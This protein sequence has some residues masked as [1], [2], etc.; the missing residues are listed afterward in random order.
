MVPLSAQA[1]IRFTED[2]EFIPGAYSETA[3]RN[4]SDKNGTYPA[5]RIGGRA[6]S[7]KLTKPAA[8]ESSCGGLCI[9]PPLAVE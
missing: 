3:L 6:I 5:P 9:C 1:D 2:A 7:H 8:G 4:I